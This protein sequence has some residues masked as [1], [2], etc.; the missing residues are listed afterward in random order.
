M[1]EVRLKIFTGNSNRALAEEICRHINVPLGEATV[2]SF[3]DGESFGLDCVGKVEAMTTMTHDAL[4][5]DNKLVDWMKKNW[6]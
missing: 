1:S 6:V 4:H 3:P 2:T 5:H